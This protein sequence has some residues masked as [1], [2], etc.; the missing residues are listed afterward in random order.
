MS[1]SGSHSVDSYTIPLLIN[2]KEVT[3]LIT[4]PVTS[5]AF[6]KTIW[7]SSSA[8]MADA[9]ATIATA[10]AAFPTQSKTKPSFRC[11]ILL[12]A[13][14][15]F[16]SYTEECAGYIIQKTK[17]KVI[18]LGGFNIPLISKI[19]KDIAGRISGIIGFIL[20]CVNK[21][22]STLVLKEPFRVILEIVPQ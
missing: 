12:K 18:F 1:A 20:V 10:S 8:S 11:N 6:Y 17:A 16:N 5:P 4:F 13:A 7:Q 9:N 15:I 22:T 19:L 21:G 2:G 14:K 3:T